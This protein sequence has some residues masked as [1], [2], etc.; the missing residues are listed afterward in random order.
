M[1]HTNRNRT[2]DR[3]IKR[4]KDKQTSTDVLHL[5]TRMTK[6][7]V[8]ALGPNVRDPAKNVWQKKRHRET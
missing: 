3:G 1:K 4:H 8:K 5:S 2:T 7:I 6:V